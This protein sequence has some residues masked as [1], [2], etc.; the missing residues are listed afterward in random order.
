MYARQSKVSLLPWRILWNHLSAGKSVV[1]TAL[2]WWVRE[3][4]T[5]YGRVCDV[6]GGSAPSY[7][8]FVNNHASWMIVDLKIRAKPSVVA[9]LQALPFQSVAFDNLCCFNVLEHV[10][11]AHVSVREIF[12][13]VRPGGQIFIS[14]RA[15]LA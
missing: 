1:R 10:Y 13:V 9:A 3:H 12:R 11:E 4:V 6:G 7:A 14:I 8:Q 15:V 5:V 2:H